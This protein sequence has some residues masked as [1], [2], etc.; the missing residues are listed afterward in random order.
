MPPARAG[1][2]RSLEMR[3]ASHPFGDTMRDCR[4][5]LSRNDQS[6][7]LLRIILR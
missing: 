2:G 6:S 1:G 4:F 7:T 5:T 3:G